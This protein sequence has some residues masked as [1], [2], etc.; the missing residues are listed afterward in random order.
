MSWHLLNRTVVVW[1]LVVGE[2]GMGG[3]TGTW[4][5]VGEVRAKVSQPTSRERVTASQGG[6]E[7]THVVHL[8]P[9]AAVRRGDQLRGSGQV[10]E[11]LAVT[12]PSR[13]G[14]YLRADCELIQAE[15]VL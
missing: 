1:R 7:L 11:V 12:G 5:Q 14:V 8:D 3:Q 2:D 6:A 13:G 15:E 9:N 4:S 10:L